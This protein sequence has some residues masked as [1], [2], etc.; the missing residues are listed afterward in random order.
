M[1]RTQEELEEKHRVFLKNMT[2]EERD[3]YEEQEEARLA[4]SHHR[5][6]CPDWHYGEG[7]KAI[8][9]WASGNYPPT[10]PSAGLSFTLEWSDSI[11][12]IDGNKV[13]RVDS[14]KGHWAMVWKHGVINFRLPGWNR[15]D[16]ESRVRA[17]DAS[18]IFIYLW[19][20]HVD[21][22]VA[23]RLAES[24]VFTSSYKVYKV[25]S[26]CSGDGEIRIKNTIHK[27]VCSECD[28]SGKEI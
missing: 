3:K 4:I 24:Y 19:C 18:A 26:K 17:R 14:D 6:E 5:T 27:V 16:G 20:K 9:D 13:E 8:I 12:D 22:G 7:T 2:P 25:C 11:I 23:V 10:R 28:G 21:P 15:N 1:K